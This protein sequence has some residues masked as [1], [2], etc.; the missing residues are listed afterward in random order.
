MKNDDII[1]M[2]TEN[3]EIIRQRLQKVGF[4]NNL[5]KKDSRFWPANVKCE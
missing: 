1:N 4:M 5:T 3:R 2:L